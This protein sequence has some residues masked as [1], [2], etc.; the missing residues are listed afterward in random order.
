[1]VTPEPKYA[2]QKR[3]R[4]AHKARDMDIYRWWLTGEYSLEAIGQMYPGED[5][6][7]LSAAR[8]HQ[9]VHRIAREKRREKGKEAT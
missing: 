7:P 2:Q 4:E 9:I 8:V 3:M 5:G 1:M 6:N